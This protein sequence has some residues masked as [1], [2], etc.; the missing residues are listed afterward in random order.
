[1]FRAGKRIRL[2]SGF[3]A[4]AGT[5]FQAKIEAVGGGTGFELRVTYN[6]LG[7]V[8]TMTS[9][10]TNKTYASYTYNEDGSLASEQTPATTRTFEYDGRGRLVSYDDGYL[11]QTISYAGYLNGNISATNFIYKGNAAQFANNYASIAYDRLG[12]LKSAD[13]SVAN[14]DIG[15]GSPLAYDRNGNILSLTRSSQTVNYAY[16]SGTN[17]VQTLSNGKSYQYDLNGNITMASDKAANGIRYDPYTQMTTEVKPSTTDFV[18]FKYDAANERVMKRSAAPAQV[19]AT[20]YLHGL[21]EYP[22]VDKVDNGERVYE[23][24]YIYGTTGLIA[25]REGSSETYIIRD[26]LGSTR[27]AISQDGS[28]GYAYS[29]DALGKM[30]AEGSWGNAQSLAWARYFYTGQERDEETGL[31]NFRARFYDED[32]FRFYSID[33]AGEGFTP[34]SFVGN[35]PLL[36]VDPTGQFIFETIFGIKALAAIVNGAMIGATVNGLAYTAAV[37][38]SSGAFKNWSWGD[39]GK[40]AGIGALNG[41]IGAAMPGMSLSENIT[42]NPSLSVGSEGV[43][44]GA[45]LGVSGSEGKFGYG[46]NAGVGYTTGAPASAMNGWMGSIGMYGGY[47]G[48]TISFM[49]SLTTYAAQNRDFTQT[50]QG[51]HLFGGKNG[52]DI[53]NP[54][55]S[56]N[57]TY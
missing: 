18:E 54:D 28:A 20:V 15:V 7:Q 51:W 47:K 43:T 3:H 17:K 34:Y 25:I 35:S 52:G 44:F 27:L 40:V 48:E 45:N 1:M 11:G 39:F 31:Q 12:R 6:N 5:R 2:Q 29:Y 22:L 49:T 8:Q 30:V 33:P 32:L 9:P 42:L 19:E 46:L 10:A 26:H 13:N 16:Q 56:L 53:N 57:Y 41:A 55:W 50:I 37:A 14:Y 38:S 23:R 21:S 24:L 4:K 36:Y